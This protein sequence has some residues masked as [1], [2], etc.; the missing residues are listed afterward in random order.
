MITFKVLESDDQPV[1]LISRDD[2]L[3]GVI[4]QYGEGQIRLASRYYDGVITEPG[5]P[6]A[7]VIKF[8]AEPGT[9]E[10]S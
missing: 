8:S 10:G 1:V 2:K 9:A 5:P 3:L 4:H 7:V 6:P